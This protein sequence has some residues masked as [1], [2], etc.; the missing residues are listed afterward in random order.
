MF[1]SQIKSFIIS[2][3]GWRGSKDPSTKVPPITLS[4]T[5]D[6]SGCK[7]SI[8]SSGLGSD[9]GFDAGLVGVGLVGVGLVGVGL[10]GA[11]FVFLTLLS[12]TPLVESTVG[13]PG[14]SDSRS[15][16]GS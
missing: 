9:A 11:G 8:W 2:S 16:S 4:L 12:V 3:T 6:C 1:K 15:G 13:S 7:P 10:V 5:A 14:N